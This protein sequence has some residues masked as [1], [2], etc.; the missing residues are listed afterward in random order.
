M[1]MLRT[2]SENNMTNCVQCVKGAFSLFFTDFVYFDTKERLSLQMMKD[3]GVRFLFVKSFARENE[4]YVLCLARIWKK[5]VPLLVDLMDRLE[6]RILF[7]GHGDY[8]DYCTELF[9]RADSNKLVHP[10]KA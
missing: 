3:S 10:K 7:S 2:V 8:V 9:N 4:P 1:V 6:K 5:D